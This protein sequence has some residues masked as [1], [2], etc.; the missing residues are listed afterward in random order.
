[1]A[2]IWTGIDRISSYLLN[3]FETD[4]HS[5]HDEYPYYKSRGSAVGIATAYGLDD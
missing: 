2:A 4:E 5:F 3:K 1:M